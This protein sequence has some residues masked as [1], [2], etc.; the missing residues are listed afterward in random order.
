MFQILEKFH[1]EHDHISDVV[2]QEFVDK[3]ISTEEENKRLKN[4]ISEVKAR[5]RINLERG[6]AEI[7]MVKK[8]KEDELEELHKR[9]D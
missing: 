9:Y 4:E 6:K 8:Q 7:E 5:H 1:E 2:R 3:I